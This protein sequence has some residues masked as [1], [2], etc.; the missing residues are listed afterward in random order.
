MSARFDITR[1]GF[2]KG[3]AASAGAL[4]GSRLPGAAWLPEARAAAGERSA[5]VTIF[6]DG[7]YNALFS[8][9][10]SFRNR[11]FGVSDGNIA[12]LGS[13]LMV[14]AG[15]LGSLPDFAKTH[16]ASIG[17]RHGISAHEAAQPAM[18]FDGNRNYGVHLAR[19]MGGDGAIKCAQLGR[20]LYTPAPKPA[21]EGVSFQRIDSLDATIRALG[22]GPPD[23]RVPA[24][25]VAA[26]AIA[27]S[28][29]MSGH[30]ARK[31]PV[32]MESFQNG[33]DTSIEVLK[34]PVKPFV[35]DEIARNYTGIETGNPTAIDGGG[36]IFNFEGA[37]TAV[38]VANFK[39]QMTGAELLIRA[40]ANVV[41][42]HH[43][44]WDSHGDSS[45]TRVRNRWAQLIQPGLTSFINRMT[46][47][48]EL[49][50]IN[51]VVAI[52]GDLSRSLPNS[53]HQPNLTA[54]VIGKYVKVGST[55]RA[56]ANADLPPGTPSIPQFWAYLAKVLRVPGDPFGANPHALVL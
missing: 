16:M 25:N 24:R 15:S 27:L 42:I 34:K 31:H 37:F 21:E 51:V 38:D 14:D 48:P 22:G 8:S 32:A 53:D 41:S 40:G 13:G 18:W 47:D 30:A 1:R 35:Y 39:T 52:F 49:S 4:A 17:I 12:D 28:Q 43:P 11:A 3:L 26:R 55:G 36:S 10:D 56:S 29:K 7:G 6:L 54:T 46:S 23:P 9:A 19:L 44:A 33:Y 2:L 5:L 20:D 50:A 45:G